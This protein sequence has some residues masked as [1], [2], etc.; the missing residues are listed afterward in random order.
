MSVLIRVDITRTHCG[1]GGRSGGGGAAAEQEEAL[2]TGGA[3]TT[4]TSYYTFT[5]ISLHCC[6]TWVTPTS[7][8]HAL[9]AS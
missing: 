2:K 3:A 4:E 8:S 1:G 7:A 6:K 5:Y 9:T